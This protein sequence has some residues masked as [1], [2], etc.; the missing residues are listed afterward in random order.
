MINIAFVARKGWY[1]ARGT[2]EA[3]QYLHKDGIWRNTTRGEDRTFS[4]YFRSEKAV[5]EMA[6]KFDKEIHVRP[7]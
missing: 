4:G 2:G 3:A 1:A 7:N 5:R 6:E